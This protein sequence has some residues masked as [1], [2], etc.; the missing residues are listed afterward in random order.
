M[1]IIWHIFL[2][3]KMMK[4]LR[5]EQEVSNVVGGEPPKCIWNHALPKH[6]LYLVVPDALKYLRPV[7]SRLK[8][9]SH[10]LF[11]KSSYATYFEKN[12]NKPVIWRVYSFLN[13]KYFQIEW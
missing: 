3:G 4:H 2:L 7:K 12:P 11:S 8:T 13:L 5:F 1:A 9:S 10:V 6:H